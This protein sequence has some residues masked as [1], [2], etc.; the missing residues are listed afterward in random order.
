VDARARS[1]PVHVHLVAIE[2]EL[3]LD[4]HVLAGKGLVDLEEVDIGER[5]PLLFE[6][7]PDRGRRPDSHLRWLDTDDRPVAH[8]AEVRA[9]AGGGIRSLENDGRSAVHDPRGVPGRHEAILREDDGELRELL[10]RRLGP[11]V[12][13]AI[14]DDLLP[15]LLD[16][17][18]GDLLLE[19]AG[20]LRPPRLAL[21]PDREGVLLLATEAVAMGELLGG[22][23]HEEPAERVEE[24]DHEE[25]LE[26]PLSEAETRTRA[27]DDVRA[28][29]HVLHA[30]SENGRRLAELDELGPGDDRLDPRSAEA[31]DGE[32]GHLE[33]HA[34][35]EPDVAGP[36]DHLGR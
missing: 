30:A 10:Q 33:R 17:D 16:G 26:L 14:D 9:P 27:P 32:R 23:R 11:E 2:P 35:L 19:E 21:A 34:G 7:L 4:G 22:L 36:V 13:V 6:E 15:A 1:P 20:S 12:V 29:A 18:R 8:R 24:S 5:E 28:L 25:I 3:A 31:V